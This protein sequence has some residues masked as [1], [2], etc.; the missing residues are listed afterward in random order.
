M[1]LKNRVLS[2]LCFTVVLFSGIQGEVHAAPGGTVTFTDSGSTL[3]ASGLSIVSGVLEISSNV[4][5]KPSEIE[6]ALSSGNLE[7]VATGITISSDIDAPA[8]HSLTLKST[9][10]ISLDPGVNITSQSGDLKLWADSDSSSGG[11]ILLGTP[12]AI[13]KCT[14]ASHGGNISLGGGT[15]FSTGFASGTS[16]VPIAGK[17]IF[18]IGIW[19]CELNSGSGNISL[20]GSTGTANSSVRA[21]VFENNSKSGT[22]DKPTFVT[23]GAGSVNV[24]GDASQSATGTNTWG[25]T[26]NLEVSTASGD[27]TVTGKS[28]NASGTNRRG[29]AIGNF[30]FNSTS[31]NVLIQDETPG[32]NSNFSGSYLN[33]TSS[34][35]TAGSINISTDKFNGS[36]FTSLTVS[37]GPVNISPYN[38]TFGMAF[39][40]GPIT[41]TNAQSLTIGSSGNTSTVSVGNAITVGGPLTIYG[42]NTTFSAATTSS[43]LNLT[44]SGS[45]TQSSA[46]TASSVSLQG[47]GS[48]ALTNASNSFGTIAAGSSN[49]RIGTLS[50]VDST[51]GFE[52]GAV[53]G[54]SGIYSND[55]VE[56][57][58]MSGNLSILQTISSTKA[59]GDSVKLFA[60][61]DAVA[62]AAG[63]G[64]LIFSG[65][66]SVNVESGARSLLYSGTKTSSTGI[67]CVSNGDSNSRM[68]VDS[69]TTVSSINPS[70]NATGTYALFRVTDGNQLI[71]DSLTSS[72]TS[73]AAN[74]YRADEI[75]SIYFAA[76]SSKLS[77]SAKIQISTYIK[78]NS[79]SIYK[80]VGHVQGTRITKNG[81]K[82]AIA[83][84]TAVKD[85]LETIGANVTFTVVIENGRIPLN[86][87]FK[88]QSRRA[89]IFA[90]TP[91]VL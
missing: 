27:I 4:S 64:N 44:N 48:F 47:T 58:T 60:D 84:A 10:N 86:K 35:S 69:T 53:G 18:G 79:S 91:V 24:Y 71:C 70:L 6:S 82:L 88:S 52:I 75:G 33:G 62:E 25:P 23:T 8:S 5:L 51:G 15:D 81:D 3:S 49:S 45:V 57:S 67:G 76:N 21:I 2:T 7:V 46:I 65:S 31:G 56:I 74:G 17:P 29:L 66:G 1:R 12:T 77:K 90:M 13:T 16:S 20:R 43:S 40:L 63:D 26:G 78:N 28:N 38:S 83:R 22:P 89:T 42:S 68:G 50:V 32:T 19:G 14:I 87:G 36:W 11:Y 37:T 39:T 85:Y 80:V 73:P 30:N 41:A 55:S 9:G 59:S 61:K 72:S 54:L 34:I